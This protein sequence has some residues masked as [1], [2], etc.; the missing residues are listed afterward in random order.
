MLKVEGAE[1]FI[2]G[3]D[4]FLLAA[5]KELAD[6]FRGFA[7]AVFHRVAINT[8]Q[9]SGN[10]ASNWNFSVG[11]VDT[12]V[13][14]DLKEGNKLS[15]RAAGGPKR[16]WSTYGAPVAQA[17]D[18]R[19]IQVAVSRNQGRDAE[20]K[21]LSTSVYLTNSAQDL[22]RKGYMNFLEEN[23]EGFLRPENEPGHMVARTAAL[24]GSLGELTPDQVYSLRS[25]KFGDLTNGGVL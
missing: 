16:K 3:I 18:P 5:E 12:S 23:P 25:L 13:I 6:V 10:A 21:G 14:Y 17:G 19:A 11:K 9:W 22:G 24:A 8:P 2:K 20:V 15:A 1:E 7:V 4:D